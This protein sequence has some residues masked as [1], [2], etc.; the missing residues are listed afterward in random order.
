[1]GRYIG[2]LALAFL[3]LLMLASCGGS[4]A[5]DSDASRGASQELTRAAMKILGAV[6]PDGANEGDAGWVADGEALAFS[7]DNL[8]EH[9]NGGADIYYEYGFASLVV[10]RYAWDD[11]V[12]SIDMYTMTDADAAF[13]I[14]SYNRHPTLSP[15]AVGGDGTIH[16]GGLFFRQDRYYVD[17]RQLGG[18]PILADEFIALAE[19]MS[20]EIGTSPE[21]PAIM[22]LLPDKGMIVRSAVFARG[23]LAINNQVYIAAENM[24][25]LKQ[26]ET[27]ALARYRLGQHEFSGIIAEYASEEGRS[28]AFGRLRRH[29]LGEESTRENEFAAALTSGKNYAVREA[30]LRLL[31][32]ANAD[33]EKN[34]LEMLERLSEHAG[35]EKAE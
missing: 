30:G 20:D 9:I 3:P 27:A 22:K 24:F 19:A 35:T 14:Y 15:V 13:G 11:K 31:V 23:K 7:G 25:G 28:A 5:A 29:F 10:Q 12:V 6:A 33:S 21:A 26:G 17:I 32:V 18:A 4:N 8:Y 2:W 1:M 34:A 16:Q